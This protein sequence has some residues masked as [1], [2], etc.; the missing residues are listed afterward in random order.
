MQIQMKK[1][2]IRK[3][4][5]QLLELMVAMFILLVCLAPTMRI[6]TSMH[7]AQYE[8]IRD[9]YQDHLM[10]KIHGKIT[11]LLYKQQIPF[12]DSLD[13][14][15][16]PLSDP[17]IDEL[18]KK[19]SYSC[20]CKLTIVD[21]Y[22]P[23]GQEN[24]TMYLGKIKMTMKDHAFKSRKILKENKDSKQDPSETSYEYFVYIDSGELDKTA[25]DKKS[26]GEEKKSDD[27]EPA[28]SNKPINPKNKKAGEQFEKDDVE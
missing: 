3:H 23:R 11:E 28:N 12:S 22:T 27:Q 20:K 17:E 6:F 9:N 1:N 10:H 25:K 2:Q 5:F 21:K 16:I 26:T 13:G 24:P 15:V 8:M 18:L 4:H 14:N 7:L 19:Y